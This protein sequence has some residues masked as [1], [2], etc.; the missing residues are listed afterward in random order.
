VVAEA[1]TA[2]SRRI[3]AFAPFGTRWGGGPAGRAATQ[4]AYWW[5]QMRDR[6]DEATHRQEA[7]R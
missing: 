3:D 1:I 7:E 2:R 5:Y 6:I 4:L